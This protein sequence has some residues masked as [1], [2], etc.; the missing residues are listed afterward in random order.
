MNYVLFLGCGKVQKCSMEIFGGGCCF[1]YYCEKLS[2]FS[3]FYVFLYFVMS[4]FEYLD[5]FYLK[6]Q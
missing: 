5:V 2:F 6:D 3:V 1:V 4:Y